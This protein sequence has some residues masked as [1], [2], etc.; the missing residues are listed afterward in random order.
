MQS[1]FRLMGTELYENQA[2]ILVHSYGGDF[3]V[4]APELLYMQELV[5][6][7]EV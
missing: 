7:A 5:V 2:S 4:A 1:K 3:T 6:L